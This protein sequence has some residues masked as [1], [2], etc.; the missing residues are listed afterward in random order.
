MTALYH[1]EQFCGREHFKYKIIITIMKNNG[2]KLQL[3]LQ[4]SVSK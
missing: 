1:P 4:I 2:N 3:N